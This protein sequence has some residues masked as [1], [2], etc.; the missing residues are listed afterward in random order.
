[1]SD[2]VNRGFT[3]VEI[4]VVLTLFSVLAASALF[5]S[6]ETYRGTSFRSD[7]DL[8]IAVF[9]RARAESM[10]NICRGVGCMDGTPHGVKVLTDG[11]VVLFQGAQYVG[12]PNTDAVF[13]L[14]AATTSDVA[15]VVFAP[16][17]GT[18]TPATIVLSGYDHSSTIIIS[19]NGRISWTH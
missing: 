10:N 2:R 9:Q 13:H 12:D 11:T 19:P 6:M 17:S 3:M 7:R 16:L 15:E 14:F 5:V 4:L 8:L 1:M 18:T